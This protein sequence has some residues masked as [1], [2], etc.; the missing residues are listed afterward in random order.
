MI[1]TE[2]QTD[3]IFLM[4]FKIFKTDTNSTLIYYF[5]NDYSCKTLSLFQSPTSMK[6][7][8]RLLL[9]GKSKSLAEDLNTEYRLCQRCVED[10]DFYEGVRAG[11]CGQYCQPFDLDNPVVLQKVV[12][13]ANKSLLIVNIWE[14]YEIIIVKKQQHN[15]CSILEC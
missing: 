4:K 11:K 8:L 6:I 3:G 12:F 5:V 7:T 1:I 10:R 2:K 15:S 14:N 13:L 9:E